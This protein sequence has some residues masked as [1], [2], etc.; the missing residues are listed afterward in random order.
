MAGTCMRDFSMKIFFLGTCIDLQQNSNPTTTQQ[1]VSSPSI[2]S[3]TSSHAKEVGLTS[4]PNNWFNLTVILHKC[5][6]DPLHRLLK[7]FSDVLYCT[8]KFRL[9]YR[10]T[11]V[12][13]IILF[14]LCSLLNIFTSVHCV[15]IYKCL[16]GADLKKQ[17]Q[18][19]PGTRP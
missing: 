13:G 9:L 10:R 8:C 17:I 16:T 3:K 14:E 5:S 15:H 2:N 12:G 4:Q 18:G 11:L 1:Q 7:W 6:C 19:S